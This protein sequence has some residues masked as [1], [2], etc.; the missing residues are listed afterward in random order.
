M[1]S[2]SDVLDADEA[3]AIR[4]F[5]VEKGNTALAASQGPRPR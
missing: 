3:A 5:I 2:Y 4:A 1:A